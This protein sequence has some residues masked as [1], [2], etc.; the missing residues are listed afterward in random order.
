MIKY[1]RNFSQRCQCCNKYKANAPF[2]EWFSEVTCKVIGIICRKCAVRELFGSK[3]K[4]N[5]RY[6]RWIKEENER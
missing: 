3:Y 2:Y 5:T 6:H 1:M 4:Q